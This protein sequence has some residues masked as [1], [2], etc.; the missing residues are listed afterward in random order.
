MVEGEDQGVSFRTFYHHLDAA[1]QAAFKTKGVVLNLKTGKR[2]RWIGDL[3]T[4][5]WHDA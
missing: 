3:E 4:G 2:S 1:Q 5:S